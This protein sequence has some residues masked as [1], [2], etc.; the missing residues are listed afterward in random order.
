MTLGLVHLGG[1]TSIRV[2][3]LGL[4]H[5]CGLTAARS[6]RLDWFTHVVSRRRGSVRCVGDTT[7]PTL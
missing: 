7:A 6:A 4:V 5:L 3:S 1:L 2:V